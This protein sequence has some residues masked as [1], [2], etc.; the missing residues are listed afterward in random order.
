MKLGQAR[1]LE[2]ASDTP[3]LFLIDDVFG[4]L[5]PPRRNNLLAALPLSAQ[6]LVTATTL[7]WR[8]VSGSATEY[9]LKDGRITHQH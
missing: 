9:V 4:E 5:D 6:K 3:P 8:E 1:K 2:E 7:H